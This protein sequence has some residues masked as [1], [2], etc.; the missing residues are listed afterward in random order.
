MSGAPPRV[1]VIIPAYH[2]DQTL[3]SCLEALRN[4][5]FRDFETILINSSP[6]P[7]TAEI[8]RRYPE[9]VFEQSPVRLLPHAARNRGVTMAR[10][11]L[12]VFT[13]PDCRAD[14]DWLVWLVSAHDAGHPV[15]G[16]SMGLLS[17]RAIERAV[18]LRKFF[19][20]LPGLPE[21]PVHVI[22]TAN[23]SYSRHVWKR[24]GPLQGELFTG[25]ALLSLRAAAA[26]F[27]PWFEPRACV[28]HRHA[29]G[30]AAY[31]REFLARGR[32]F[33][34]ARAA[35]ESWPRRRAAVYLAL[36]PFVTMLIV[37]RSAR[38]ARRSRWLVPFLQSLPLHAAFATAWSVG[39][40]RA[41]W[42]RLIDRW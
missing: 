39:E 22:C 8:V 21:G 6:E 26:G 14:L 7:R 34:G 42:R 31:V 37:G 2:S 41:Y 40:G 13:D 19:W 16:G 15:V 11:S 36:L 29:G 20:L 1:S 25:D 38:C 10:G 30:V 9:V 35:L 4:Q 3:T 33:A 28:R 24:I 18:H 32:E 12:L 23:A 5:T 27:M 17:D